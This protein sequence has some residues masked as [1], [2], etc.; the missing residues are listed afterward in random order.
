V[1]RRQPAVTESSVTDTVVV[2]L[3]YFPPGNEEAEVE[4]IDFLRA[5]SQWTP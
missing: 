3:S 4:S 5:A 1:S 2:K